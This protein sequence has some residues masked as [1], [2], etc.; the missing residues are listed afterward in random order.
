MAS[1]T[2]CVSK[3]LKVSHVLSA[4]GLDHSL[5]QGAI[6]FSIGRETTEAEIDYVL[7]TL[8]R[9]VGKLRGMSPTW[10][11]FQRGQI[12]SLTEPR[13]STASAPAHAKDNKDFQ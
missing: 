12:D 5:G 10:D 4:L 8:P 1:G 9:L 6:L 7:D 3:A 11:E 13:S 2:S